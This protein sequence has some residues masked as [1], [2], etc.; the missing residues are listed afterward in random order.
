[1]FDLPGDIPLA[2]V[3]PTTAGES[4]PNTIE[5]REKRSRRFPGAIA[6]AETEATARSRSRC[7]YI[8]MLRGLR[9]P[10]MKANRRANLLISA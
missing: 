1:M 7:N 8:V 10:H 2:R 3:I 6:Y 9:T 4:R 5:A